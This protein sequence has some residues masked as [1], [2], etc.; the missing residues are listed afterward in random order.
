[1]E[2]PLKQPSGS[3]IREDGSKSV[4]DDL[5]FA[6]Q[7]GSINLRPSLRTIDSN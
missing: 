5:Q 6:K 3:D 7:N 2:Q 4:V 1:L